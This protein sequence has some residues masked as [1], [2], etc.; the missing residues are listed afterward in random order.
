MPV[1]RGWDKSGCYYQWGNHGRKYYYTAGDAVS[2]NDAQARAER[3]GRAAHA[4]ASN[5]M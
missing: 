5:R 1:H 3:Q 4:H 2:R